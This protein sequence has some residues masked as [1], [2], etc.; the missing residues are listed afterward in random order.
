M[1]Q[2]TFTLLLAFSSIFSFAQDKLLIAGSGWNKIAIVDKNTAEIEWSHD[3]AKGTECN[4]VRQT[5]EGN[6]MFSYKKG[7]SLIDKSNQVI[8]DFKAKKGEEVHSVVQLKNGNYFIGICGNPARFVT[9]N[10]KGKTVREQKY[11]LG[12]ER[13]HGQ[14]RQAIPTKKN[15]IIIPILARKTVIELNKRNKVVNELKVEGNPFSAKVMEDGKWLV[16]CGDAHKLMISD[17]K[18]KAIERTITSDDLKDNAFCFVAETWQLD[19]GNFLIANWNGHS[20]DKTQPKVMEI[21]TNNNVVWTLPYNSA[22]SNISA[23]E[24]LKN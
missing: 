12:V 19:N 6:I 4:S 23:V 7:A 22:I 3:L 5:A 24:V 14:F 16:A 18:H 2:L 17:A 15:T 8:W 20:K 13:P 11:D 9:L 21:D 10:K 1:K